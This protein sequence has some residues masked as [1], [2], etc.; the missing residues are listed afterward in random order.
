MCNG[1]W[2]AF[3]LICMADTEIS[4]QG[5]SLPLICLDKW[6]YGRTV[7][8]LSVWAILRAQTC[9][10]ANQSGLLE[11]LSV[12]FLSH[13]KHTSIYFLFFLIIS[14]RIFFF[15]LPGYK[16]LYFCSRHER[17]NMDVSG[18]LLCFEPLVVSGGTA[19]TWISE[20]W[21]TADQ[22]DADLW[23]LTS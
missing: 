19:A 15:L 16:Y 20:F 7:A 10:T 13:L 6:L 21:L 4:S 23:P 14:E 5:H 2:T 18:D 3:V 22:S 17:F 1:V 11:S 8:V 9:A 12:L